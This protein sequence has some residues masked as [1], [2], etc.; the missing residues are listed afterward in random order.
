MFAENLSPQGNGVIA[1]FNVAQNVV[2]LS[3][4][5]FSNFAAVEAATTSVDGS[6]VIH[7]DSNASV[8]LQG[9]AASS[10]QAQNFTFV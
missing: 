9:V 3:A 4:A 2:R 7:F 5:M 6:A 1:G 10:L 8:T